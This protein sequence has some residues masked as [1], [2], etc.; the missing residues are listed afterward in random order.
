MYRIAGI[1]VHKKILAVVVTPQKL[2]ILC[3]GSFKNL[4][5]QLGSLPLELSDL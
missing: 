5:S 1:D 4:K 3:C 2:Q